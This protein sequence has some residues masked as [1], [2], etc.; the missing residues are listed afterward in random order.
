MYNECFITD[1]YLLRFADFNSF[2][3]QAMWFENGFVKSTL[4]NVQHLVLTYS[5]RSVM[6]LGLSYSLSFKT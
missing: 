2:L 5:S 6:S 4:K 3:I 1:I